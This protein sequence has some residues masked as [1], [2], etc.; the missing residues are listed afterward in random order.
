MDLDVV[1][2]H[3]DSNQTGEL[4]IVLNNCSPA[5]CAQ[6]QIFHFGTDETILF[7]FWRIRTTLGTS[8]FMYFTEKI[9][10]LI[11][12]RINIFYRLDFWA[13][14]FLGICSLVPNEK[15]K[16]RG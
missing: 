7:E 9:R 10:Q 14:F 16:Q 1:Q 4:F 2:H 6:L 3:G 5:L 11:V 8:F 12:L 15:G 13:V